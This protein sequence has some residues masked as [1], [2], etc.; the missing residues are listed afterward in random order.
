VVI[1]CVA[2]VAAVPVACQKTPPAG[3]EKVALS[4]QAAAAIKSAFPKATLGGDVVVENEIGM[5]L[6]KAQLTRNGM[7]IEVLVAPDGTIVEVER[8]IAVKSLPEA[9]AA[10]VAKVSSGAESVKVMKEEVRAEM[11]GGKLV[12][13]AAPR[14]VY[15]VKMVKA[16]VSSEVFLAPDGSLAGSRAAA[17]AAEAPKAE[18]P[19]AD[20]GRQSFKVNKANLASTGENPYFIPLKPGYRLTLEAGTTR[21]VITVLDE[22]KMVDGVETRIIEERETEAGQ[23][24]EI[25]RNYFA[26][27]K[28]TQD[29]YYFGEDVDGYSGGKVT[30]HGGAWWSGVQGATFG[31]MMPGRPKVGDKY[32]QEVAP[33]VAMD[34]AE[35]VAI[36]EPYETPAGMFA[37][38][39]RTREDSP[40]ESGTS[41]KRYAL[42][43]GLIKD[44]ELV[45]VKVEPY[46][47]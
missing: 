19:V 14:V 1:A 25:S 32:Y 29:V 43:V 28:T 44:D 36:D 18:M 31:L 3:A 8:E 6:F 27:D 42:G 24:T 11:A 45:L 15:A 34:R 40:L 37:M 10:A 9:L 21:L 46:I 4:A 35:I 5:D 47:E 12:K 2:T 22:T 7:G 39:L 38:C 13:L 20:T 41:E 17:T 23:L 33:G 16:G 26:I 30:G